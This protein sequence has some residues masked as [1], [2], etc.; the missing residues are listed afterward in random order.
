MTGGLSSTNAAII[1]GVLLLM[2]VVA[3]ILVIIAIVFVVRVRRHCSCCAV[4]SIRLTL[5]IM[6]SYLQ[7]KRVSIGDSVVSL[8]NYY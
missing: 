5:L 8:I 2:A 7:K 6:F 4:L 3:V 1:G